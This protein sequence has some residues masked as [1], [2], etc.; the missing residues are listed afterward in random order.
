[1]KHSTLTYV[2]DA[3]YTTNNIENFFG[4]FK[5]GMRGTYTFCGEQHLK[6]YLA[7]FEFR[8]NTTVPV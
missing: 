2:N 1:M 5:R 3:G 7:E 4:I 8:H 6:R